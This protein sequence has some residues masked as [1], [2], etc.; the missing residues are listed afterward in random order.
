MSSLP[1]RQSSN[2]L[3]TTYEDDAAT[4]FASVRH[5]IGATNQGKGCRTPA[6]SVKGPPDM[7]QTSSS[8]IGGTHGEQ[9]ASFAT[10]AAA[11]VASSSVS[12]ATPT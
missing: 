10:F 9:A 1:F 3:K 4:D 2:D 6:F 5:E 8:V 7:D 11:T 12:D